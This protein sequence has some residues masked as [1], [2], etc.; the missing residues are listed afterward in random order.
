[1]NKLI[2]L[3]RLSVMGI[4]K[5]GST[6]IPYLAAGIFSAFIFFV[7]SSILNNDLMKKL[8]HSGYVWMLMQIG[9]FLL[10]IILLP[11]MMYANGFL[12]KR[13]KKELGL[14]SI[15]GLE[16]KHIALMMVCETLFIFGVVIVGGIL[17]GLVFSKLL[18]LILLNVC[19][20]PVDTA[21]SFSFKAVSQSAL[22]FLV[23]YGLNLITNL[24]QV[25]RSSPN[26]LIKGSKKGDMEPKR[27]WITALVGLIFLGAGYIIAIPA[28]IDSGIFQDFLL[29]VAFVVFGTHQ[30]F[31]A[32]LISL[33]KILKK[34]IRL[35]YRESNYVTI[36]GML[37]RMKGSASS[38]ANICIFGTMTIVT[39]L[40]TFSLWSGTDSM[41]NHQFP[42]DVILNYNAGEL[43][44][45][46]SLGSKL[47]EL[48]NAEQ[49]EIKDKIEFNYVKLHVGKS[50]DAFKIQN[51][52]YDRRDRF[53]LKLIS[54]EEYNRMEQKQET[55]SDNEVMIFAAGSDFGY[56]RVLLG[57]TE[58]KVKKELKKIVFDSKA[59]NDDFGQ[60]FYIIMK[61]AVIIDTLRK[62]FKSTAVDDRILTLRFQLTGA[63]ENKQEFISLICDWSSRQAGYNS[64]VNG[65]FGRQEAIS[66][67]GGLLF[68]GIFFSIIFS[69]CLILIMYYK[70]ITEGYDDRESFDIMQKVGMSDTE[71]RSTIKRQILMVFFLPMFMAV[72]HTMAGFMM[73]TRL[74]GSLYLFD[75]GLI[76]MCG[77]GV[78]G[79]F[80]VLYGLSYAMTS[81]TY[82]RIVKQMNY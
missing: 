62:D 74:L 6:Y 49:V 3:P 1:M 9:Q 13:R 80:T 14:Y 82:Y 65:I 31:K 67:N 19:R 68:L 18:F 35:Y 55:L 27:L 15:L 81:R 63:E 46:D 47:Q 10:A 75:V 23:V 41:M 70:Q 12:M 51:S 77:I 72:L 44:D 7:F 61:D 33:L 34:N 58:Y 56:S 26:D 28:K 42:Y 24:I 50:N 45:Y 52:T 2:L 59:V 37:H 17:F 21:F 48:S 20:L 78:V 4:R 69:M 54:L 57:N 25:F 11:F 22:Y 32:G 40:C 30:F 73:I 64:V 36:S 38:L 39:L 76:A 71:V 16:K 66:M 29:A 60:D 8:P 43:R 79:L 5:N 53:A